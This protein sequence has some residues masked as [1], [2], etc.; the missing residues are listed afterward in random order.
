MPTLVLTPHGAAPV[1]WSLL[2]PRAGE[3]FDVSV[4]T[5]GEQAVV[6]C[7]RWW[8]QAEEVLVMEMGLPFTIDVDF[9]THGPPPVALCRTEHV[10][11][12]DSSWI[13]V[14]NVLRGAL[15]RLPPDAGDLRVELRSLL[16]AV[17]QRR[18][19]QDRESRGG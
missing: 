14:E 19:A 9:E 6:R 3:Q 17:R 5:R 7:Q 16:D 4:W 15:W 18:W 11:H 1:V 12:G 10:T 2:A 13:A 8:E